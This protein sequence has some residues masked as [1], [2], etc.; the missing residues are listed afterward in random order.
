MTGMD[1]PFLVRR[2]CTQILESREKDSRPI[3]EYR[4]E[5][6]YVLLGDPGAGKTEAFEQEAKQSGCKYIKA[7]DFATLEPGEELSGKTL[8]IDALDEMRVDGSDARTPLDYIRKHLKRIGCPRFRLSCREADWLGESDGAALERISPSGKIAVLHLDPLTDED[9]LEILRYDGSVG[10]PEEFLH[11]AGEH[12]LGEILRNPQTLKLLVEAVG[13]NE[14]PQSR[15]EIYQMACRQLVGEK[16]PEHRQAK[17]AASPSLDAL[18][19]AAGYLCA[20][21]LLSG[22]SGFALDAEA[23]GRQHCNLQAL[24]AHDLPL[25]GALKTNLFQKDGEEQRNP[26]HRSVAEYLGARYVASRVENG[27]L[28]FGRVLALLTGE[29]GGVMPDLRGLAAWLSVHCRGGCPMLIER[30]PLGVVLY[31]DVRNFPVADKLRV[32]SALETEAR[33][34]PWFRSDDWS[35]S[36]FGALGT[37]DMAPQFREILASPS[38][39]EADQA[40]LNC[41]LDA[42]NY[43]DPMPELAELLENIARDCSF[44]SSIRRSA[45]RAWMHVSPENTEGLLKLA[46]DIHTGIIEDRNNEVLG[47]LLY[48]LYPRFIPPSRILDYLYVQK[49][50]NHAIRYGMFWLHRLAETA[51]DD[52]LILLDDLSKR[53]AHLG[54]VLQDFEF[55]RIA[56]E[57]LVRGLEAHGESISDQRLFD[58]LGTGLDKDEFTALGE[59]HTRRVVQWFA[60][61]PDRYKAV[62]EQG[63][64]RCAGPENVGYCMNR[65]EMRLHGATP[66]AGIENWYLD[67]AATESNRD[68]AGYF[69]SQGVHALLRQNGRQD[70]TLSDLE[71]LEPWI[72]TNPGFQHW[73]EP[74]ICCPVTDWRRERVIRIRE[75]QAE[76]QK[77]KNEWAGYFREHLDALRAGAAHPQ[78]LFDLAQIYRGLIYQAQGETPDERLENFLDKDAELIDAAHCGFRRALDRGDLPAVEEIIDAGIRG[79]IYFILPAALVGMDELYEIDPSRALKLEDGVLSRLLAFRLTHSI[80]KDPAWFSALLA[81]RPELA[82]QILTDYAL[83]ALK[84]GKEHVSGL[85]ELG[86]DDAYAEVARIALLQLLEGFPL[87][88]RKLQLNHALDPL[89]KSALLYLDKKTLESVIARKIGLKSLDAAQRVYWLACGLIIA[90]ATYEAVVLQYIGKSE[91]R[92]GYLASFLHEGWGKRPALNFSFPQTTLS[93]LIELLAPDCSPERPEGVHRVGPA[94]QT[95]DLL[96]SYIRILS[97][98]PGEE[99][100]RELERLLALP[101]LFHWHTLLRGALHDQRITRRKATFRYLGVEQVEHTLANLQPANAADLAALAL[102]HLRDIARNI[103][104]GSTNDYRQYWSYDE[105]NQTLAKPKPENDCRDALLSDLKQRLGKLGIDAE[106]EGNY[107]DDKRAD[108]KISYGGAGGY[109]VPIEIKKDTHSDLWRAMRE[110]LIPGYVRD[111]G[112]D[113]HGIFLAFWF[114][115]AGMP[116]PPDGKKP[117]NAAELEN[118]LRQTLLP[119]EAHRIR[120]C[121][122]DCALP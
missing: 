103:R 80:G 74:F 73:L 81:Q 117:R 66:P 113:G 12:R 95:A 118:R 97:A 20:V 78:L 47:D 107:A 30:D 37:M 45:V 105:R 23:S 2:T 7:R 6:A 119:E 10:N 58:W 91:V 106:R 28:P 83:R 55:N 89:L 84:S 24:M 114:G 11:Q 96:K 108:I 71:Y 65:C 93:L 25:L 38:R 76:Q 29:D 100:S 9:I 92:R 112:A 18:L 34:Y 21:Q 32:L 17:R 48:E 64:L 56:G 19:N 121:V 5:P 99:A 88:A 62:I 26:V 101:K 109:N 43:G 49:G 46:E 102:D 13:A 63:A 40:L 31:G 70:L 72:K 115:G 98:N 77:I 8:F 42:I 50:N 52:L 87:R 33:N 53:Q 60:T 59:A 36:P 4:D 67:K 82:A 85:H 122:I 51:N 90:P 35:A 16:N 44:K 57:L 111:P 94:M 69:F 14:W 110:Q 116:P 79:K 27:G 68:L 120:I 104:D 1:K 15:N 3:E 39:T 75:R 54:N 86:H 22:I 61:R 41:V